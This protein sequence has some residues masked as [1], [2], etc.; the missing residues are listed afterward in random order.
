M[1]EGRE[2]H[3]FG[4]EQENERWPKVLALT[5]GMRGVRVSAEEQSF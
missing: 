1:S 2:F 5:W 4:A 3:C